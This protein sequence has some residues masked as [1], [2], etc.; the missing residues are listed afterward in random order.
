MPYFFLYFF[1]EYWIPYTWKIYVKAEELMAR[2]WAQSRYRVRERGGLSFEGF[3]S[4]IFKQTLL[5]V[6]NRIDNY[7]F[8]SQL[9]VLEPGNLEVQS[10]N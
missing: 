9:N 2:I 6:W 7:Y 8:M 3:V 4:P 10:I 1:S 5:I